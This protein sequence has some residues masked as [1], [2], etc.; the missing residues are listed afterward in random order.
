MILLDSNILSILAKVD[1]LDLLFSVLG[2]DLAVS[3]NA[4]RELEAG[5]RAGH[6]VL[7]PALDVIRRGRVKVVTLTEAE[8]RRFSHIPFGPEKGE[9][10]SLAYCLEH[11]VTFLTNDE[12]AYRRGKAL[13]ANCVLF[14]AFLR[15]MWEDGVTSREDVRRLITDLAAKASMVVKYQDEIFADASD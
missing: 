13:G 6:Q 12:R 2:E 14:K 15:S 4:H 8:H 7:Q 9:T 5:V 1:R 11:N 3:P 10:D